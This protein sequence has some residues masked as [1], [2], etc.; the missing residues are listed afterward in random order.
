MLV[1]SVLGQAENRRAWGAI[2]KIAR[3]L[4]AGAMV[5]GRDVLRMAEAVERGE[6]GRVPAGAGPHGDL[7]RLAVAEQ[8]E[9]VPAGSS[10]EGQ[11]RPA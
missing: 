6:T 1:A 10:P 2:G 11:D 3:R 4:R 5:R 7:D 8:E 9:P